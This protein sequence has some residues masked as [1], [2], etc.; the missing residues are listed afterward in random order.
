[1]PGTAQK[2]GNMDY[3]TEQLKTPVKGRY[4]LIVV[5]GRPGPLPC[6]GAGFAF[7]LKAL[8]VKEKATLKPRRTQ[9]PAPERAKLQLF[10]V[11]DFVRRLAK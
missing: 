8:A 6:A 11:A 7:K 5:G 1:M 10:L 3:I 9:P 4:D 2:T